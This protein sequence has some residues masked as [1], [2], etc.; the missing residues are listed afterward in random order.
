M[1]EGWVST[2]VVTFI[3]I[4]PIVNPF[5]TAVVF[6]TIT[7]GFGEQRRNDQARLACIYMTVVL[8]VF[9]VAGVLIME[10][11][12]ISIPGVRI[13]GGLVVARVGFGMLSP[14][15]EAPVSSAS[16]QEATTMTDVAFTPLAMPMLSGPGAIAVTIGMAAEADGV[17]ETAAT[18]IGIALTAFVSYLV[19]RASQR[20][21][22]FMGVTGM[23]ALSR[24]MGF[25]LVC[26]G[27][28]FIGLGL[29]E[30]LAAPEF[31]GPI[32]D[33]LEAMRS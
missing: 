6:L 18:A 24:I 32:L 9:L 14:E 29:R 1:I 23:Q 10:F 25:L 2:A 15:P 33:N 27:I 7:E 11:F 8:T 13:A 26:I 3:A 22:G 19:L 28:Q 17:A 4:L 16:A 12:G 20:V 5:S 21:V 30:I 31:M